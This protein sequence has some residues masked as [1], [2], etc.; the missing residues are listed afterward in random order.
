MS[1]KRSVGYVEVLNVIVFIAIQGDL[2]TW[3]KRPDSFAI[4]RRWYQSDFLSSLNGRKSIVLGFHD[5]KRQSLTHFSGRNGHFNTALSHC[6]AC[7]SGLF[8]I[9]PIFPRSKCR[10]EKQKKYSPRWPLTLS[11]CVRCKLT[12]FIGFAT[13]NL[14]AESVKKGKKIPNESANSPNTSRGTDSI[15]RIPRKHR[16]LYPRIE[17][18]NTQRAYSTRILHT[19]DYIRHVS[20]LSMRGITWRGTRKRRVEKSIVFPTNTN[21]F[22]PH[23]PPHFYTPRPREATAWNPFSRGRRR[24]AIK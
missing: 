13:S 11:W 6:L 14:T 18:K 17:S 4:F 24:F 2:S 9:M 15:I 3:K 21:V 1:S 5:G 12:G 22:P 7:L 20:G 23:F 10:T 19:R 8:I 16:N